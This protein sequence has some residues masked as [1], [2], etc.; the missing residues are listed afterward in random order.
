MIVLLYIFV[1]LCTY[2]EADFHGSGSDWVTTRLC[3]SLPLCPSDSNFGQPSHQHQVQT[4]LH[5]YLLMACIPPQ[6]HE[7]CGKLG[8]ILLDVFMDCP[9]CLLDSQRRLVFVT[10][11]ERHVSMSDAGRRGA[12]EGRDLREEEGEGGDAS[13]EGGQHHLHPPHRRSPSHCAPPAH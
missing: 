8:R 1:R 12:A 3:S 4:Q 7:F 13:Q 11:H 6:T 2:S 5:A 9:N 10:D